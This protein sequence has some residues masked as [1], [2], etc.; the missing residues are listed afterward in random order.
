[1]AKPDAE[2]TR[3]ERGHVALSDALIAEVE[4]ADTIMVAVTPVS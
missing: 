1:M 3:E 4:A 2:L